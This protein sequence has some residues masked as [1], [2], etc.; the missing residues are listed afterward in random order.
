MDLS[1]KLASFE[2]KRLQ[3][4][5]NYTVEF[6]NKS[7]TVILIAPNGYGKTAL[8]S[9]LRDCIKL[10]LRK[11]ASHSFSEM[12]LN[13][14]DDT[15][16][17]FIRSFDEEN[18]K[19]E[20]ISLSKGVVWWSPGSRQHRQRDPYRVTLKRYDSAGKE[21]IED[22]QKFEELHPRILGGVLERLPYISQIETNR[23][24]DIRSQEIFNTEEAA[25]KYFIDIKNNPQSVEML[26]AYFP[27]AVWPK[28]PEID[29]VFIETQRLLYSQSPARDDDEKIAP[30]EEILRQAKSLSTLLNKNYSDYAARSQGLDRSFPN[31]LISRAR[32]GLKTNTDKLREGLRAIE[33]KRAELT[34]A[35]IL[36]EQADNIIATDDELLPKVIDAL[37]IYVE[38]SHDKL[39][40]YDEIFPKISV[41][42]ELMAKKLF[43]K[44]LA[45]GREFGATVFRGKNKL[46]LS[47]LSSGEKHEFIML[48]K[49]IF[50]TPSESIV[51]IDEPE[52]S[53]H[54]VWQLEFMSDLRRIQAANP[55]QSIIATHSPQIFQGC[56]HLLVD[57]ADQVDE[58]G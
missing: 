45:I 42:R 3:G 44:R 24:I 4:V 53:L 23:F 19:N 21:I 11:I 12:T 41:F 30:Q 48:Y 10:N 5:F 15:K 56:K 28:T 58:L 17:E 16:W 14:Q 49:L 9:L 13:F 43:P 27:T 22:F 40:T 32:R 38:D 54:V 39:S 47:G 1:R 8:L 20:G 51:L 36:V 52:I 2:V 33:K 46:D 55:F 31:R 25:K 35:G 6:P 50:D 29:C 34:E 7:D 26:S 57:L 37:Q 18:D